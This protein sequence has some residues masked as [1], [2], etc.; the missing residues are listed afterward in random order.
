MI[1]FILFKTGRDRVIANKKEKDKRWAA[2]CNEPD[3]PFNSDECKRLMA[4]VHEAVKDIN[5]PKYIGIL[6]YPCD[7]CGHRADDHYKEYCCVGRCDCRATAMELVHMHRL[8][9]MEYN[10]QEQD[11]G[12]KAND[13]TLNRRTGYP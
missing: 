5:A 6:E 7:E 13:L 9:D 3:N 12:D 4:E 8:Y 2:F 10:R 11:D 1:N